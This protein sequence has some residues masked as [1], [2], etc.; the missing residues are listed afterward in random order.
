MNSHLL[1]F[2]RPSHVR[3]QRADVGVLARRAW[4]KFPGLAGGDVVRVERALDGYSVRERVL[5]DPD[6]GLATFG[7]QPLRLVFQAF[8]DDGVR[9]RLCGGGTLD[10]S[11]AADTEQSART[12]QR[13][14]RVRA[15]PVHYRGP[16]CRALPGSSW[17]AQGAPRTPA[18]P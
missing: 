15:D 7:R 13:E 12:S 17:R 4:G 3:V 18:A 9:D 2:E 8:D 16:I 10:R 11:A 14:T 1:H 6:D 5:V